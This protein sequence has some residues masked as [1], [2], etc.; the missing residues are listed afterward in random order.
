M[1]PI[2]EEIAA[3]T[4]REASHAAA[5]VA[6]RRTEAKHL[7]ASRLGEPTSKRG[8]RARRC[9]SLEP[10]AMERLRKSRD[11]LLLMWEGIEEGL[12]R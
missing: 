5:Y 9:F 1:A 10:S 12:P 11:A 8:G 6:L 2:L 4:R 7:V 3:R